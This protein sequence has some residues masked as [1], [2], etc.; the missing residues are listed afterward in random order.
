MYG[1][2]SREGEI[3]E[4]GT[5]NVQSGRNVLTRLV[6]NPDVIFRAALRLVDQDG[7]DALTMRRLAADLGVAPMSLYGHV[8]NKDDLLL[9]V[10]DV[11]TAEMTLPPPGTE[12]WEALRSITRDFRRVALLHPNLVPLITTRPPGGTEG[13][14]ILEAALDALARAG[15]APPLRARAYRLL[16]S[17]AIGFV[18]LESGGYFRPVEPGTAVA[19]PAPPDS[20]AMAR[21]AETAPYL[22][23]WDSDEEFEAG[24]EA[25]IAFLAGTPRSHP[26]G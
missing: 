4:S 5:G 19:A 22:A 9:G 3:V 13:L 26:E 25:V 14:R 10:V 7:V 11:A 15:I 2:S 17:F 8:P 6:L 23:S 24:M 18:V 1:L 21:I 16:S 12:P 20:A